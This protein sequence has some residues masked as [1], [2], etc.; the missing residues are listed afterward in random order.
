MRGCEWGVSTEEAW[1]RGCE[2]GVSTEEAWMRGCEWGVSTEEGATGWTGAGMAET[3]AEGPVKTE[4][5][6][7]IA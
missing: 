6:V 5:P 2:W 1:M 7:K 3:E 4:G